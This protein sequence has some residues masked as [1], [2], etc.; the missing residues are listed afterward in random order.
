MRMAWINGKIVPESEAVVSVYDSAMM[1]G[2]TCFEMTR[3]FRH[4]Q[5]ALR[6]HMERLQR[7]MEIVGMPCG[8]D[9]GA[10]ET[11]CLEAVEANPMP[12]EDEHRLMVNVTRGILSIYRDVAPIGTNVIITDFPLRWTVQGMGRLFDTGVNAVTVW[13]R[14]GTE[15]TAKHRS[16][17]HL[18][19]ANR[20]ASKH[21]GDNW[22]L[23]MGKHGVAEGTG[24]NFFIVK[25]GKVCTPYA[26][27]CLDGISRRFV[28][29]MAGGEEQSIWTGGV[30]AADEAF[31]TATPFCIMPCCWIDGKPIGDGKP[32]PVT[33][34]LL[35]EWSRHVGV[36][37]VKQI[38][39][40]D[41]GAIDGPSPYK[42]K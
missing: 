23:L 10:F 1:F 14:I 5:F 30:E 31:F 28:L 18:L 27:Q 39:E 26:K 15:P 29:K 11:A 32:G 3:S 13:R 9:V 19:M 4:R 34:R 24:A 41:K 40:W 38:K 16:R 8:M 21:E 36:D 42:F 7:S 2:D 37:I 33:M 35:D 22:P 25:K 12:P 17:L 20:E 6:D